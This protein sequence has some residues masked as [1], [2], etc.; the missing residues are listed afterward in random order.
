MICETIILEKEIVLVAEATQELAGYGQSVSIRYH[1]RESD[2][3]IM[4]SDQPSLDA[5][6]NLNV[7]YGLAV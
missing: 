5:S 3:I 4:T 1:V 6:V 2:K 7:L